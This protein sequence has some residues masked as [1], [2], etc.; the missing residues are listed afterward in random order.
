MRNA[1]RVV[2]PYPYLDAG[3]P[4]AFAHRGGAAEGDEN[5][6]AAFARAV[7]AGYR[8][9]ETDA[10]ASADGVAVLFHDDDLRRVAGDPRR[11]EDLSWHDLR[12]M[13][14]RGEPLIPR[15][16][17]TLSAW[18]QVRFNIDVKTDAS[19][20]PTL[21]VVA[22]ARARDRVLIGSFSDARIARVR[23]LAGPRQVTSMGQRETARLWA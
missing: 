11:V 17:E 16:D 2:G 20:T 13:R 12:S 10:H 18:P 19:V 8:Y 21:D 9:L 4:I 6:A 3:G 23:V 5:T 22:S 1:R 14:L 15:L 7:D